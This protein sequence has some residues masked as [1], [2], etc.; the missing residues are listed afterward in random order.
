MLAVGAVLF[1]ETFS[2]RLVDWDWMGLPFWPRLVLGFLGALSVLFVVR[3]SL[4][5][6]PSQSLNP[7]AFLVLAGGT[8]YVTLISVVGYVIVTPVFIA[9]FSYALGPRTRRGV[10]EALVTATVATLL[11]HYVFNELLYVQFPEGLLE[12]RL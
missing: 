9:A 5:D 8:L 4:D 7:R 3:G 1:Y 6:G 12:E 2:F 11:I 10:V